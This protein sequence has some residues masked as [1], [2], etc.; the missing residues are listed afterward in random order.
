MITNTFQLPNHSSLLEL[1]TKNDVYEYFQ[2]HKPYSSLL[3]MMFTNT[4]NPPD[5]RATPIMPAS[6][7][8]TST[9]NLEITSHIC[10]NSCSFGFFSASFI[11][12]IKM[13]WHSYLLSKQQFHFYCVVTGSS[14]VHFQ[15]SGRSMIRWR[16][17]MSLQRDAL[18]VSDLNFEAEL[19][20]HN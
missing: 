14:T 8:Y 16:I 11:S 4:F 7:L 17:K 5:Q 18:L 3:R 6:T 2:I 19:G 15:A 20:R 12:L 10:Y 13:K 1:P 9:C